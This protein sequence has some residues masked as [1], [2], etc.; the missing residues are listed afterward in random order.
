MKTT[1]VFFTAA[2]IILFGC[3]KVTR[4]G[5]AGGTVAA[6]DGVPIAYDTL[7]EGDRTVVFVHCWGGNRSFWD[8]AASALASDSRV[9]KIDLAGHGASGSKREGWSIQ[10][11]AADVEAVANALSL[12]KF[13]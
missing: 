7:G 5:P 11:L 13:I 12:G 1:A 8:Q 2:G 4:P 6:A 3:A 10:G 9:V